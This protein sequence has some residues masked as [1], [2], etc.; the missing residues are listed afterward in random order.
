MVL[1]PK[2]RGFRRIVPLWST[3]FFG[4]FPESGKTGTTPKRPPL[5]V[6]SVKRWSFAAKV[7]QLFIGLLNSAQERAPPKTSESAEANLRTA[8]RLLLWL[9]RLR[10]RR[11]IHGQTQRFP[12]PLQ[13]SPIAFTEPVNAA[14]PLQAPGCS[15]RDP[16]VRCVFTPRFFLNSIL[17]FE[18]LTKRS[19]LHSPL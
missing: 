4:S 12:A 1:G 3:F 18:G 13:L 15:L 8:L 11:Q 6:L 5:S 10:C 14:Q 17:P 2:N 19:S 9:R 16:A 7:C